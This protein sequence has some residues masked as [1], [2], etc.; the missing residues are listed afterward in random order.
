MH[1]SFG[2]GISMHSTSFRIGIS[3]QR[4]IQPFYSPLAGD[5]AN[6]SSTFNKGKKNQMEKV[7]T[8]NNKFW[9]KC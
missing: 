7:N 3:D 9:K 4:N 8:N 2:I 5:S 6:S 1:A